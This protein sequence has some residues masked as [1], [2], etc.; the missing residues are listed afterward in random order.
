MPADPLLGGPFFPFEGELQVVPLAEPVLPEPV[1]PEPPRGGEP[2]GE[3]VE[4]Q[5]GPR[6]DPATPARPGPPKRAPRDPA[7][8]QLTASDPSLTRC[9]LLREQSVGLA[10]SAG[11]RPLVDQWAKPSPSS[12]PLSDAGNPTQPAPPRVPC[13]PSRA[14]CGDLG[15]P[16]VAADKNYS[17]HGPHVDRCPVD[18]GSLPRTPADTLS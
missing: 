7:I 6:T 17:A 14:G 3:Q 2:G 16:A 5:Y 1:L 13:E 9:H 10:P 12:E 15:H 18:N 8:G 4:V 11:L